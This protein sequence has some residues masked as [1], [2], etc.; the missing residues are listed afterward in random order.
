MLSSLLLDPGT[1]NIKGYQSFAAEIAEAL[2]L[3]SRYNTG[4]CVAGR[5]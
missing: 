5:V 4:D 3:R 2:E 1:K